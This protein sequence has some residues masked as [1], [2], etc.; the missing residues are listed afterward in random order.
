MHDSTQ[1]NVKCH[2]LQTLHSRTALF[3]STD[4]VVYTLCL[5]SMWQMSKQQ[6]C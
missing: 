5:A 1:L 4:T 3:M 6:N 2:K